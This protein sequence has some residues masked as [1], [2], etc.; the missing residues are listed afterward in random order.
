MCDTL[1]PTVKP[2]TADHGPLELSVVVYEDWS[3]LLKPVGASIKGG[4]NKISISDT[5]W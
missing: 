4:W 3:L 5:D 1:V 2:C